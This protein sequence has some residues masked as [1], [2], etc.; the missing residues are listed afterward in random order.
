M[1]VIHIDAVKWVKMKLSSSKKLLCLCKEGV[2]T[3]KMEAMLLSTG[4]TK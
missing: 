1:N 4:A 2:V 3:N